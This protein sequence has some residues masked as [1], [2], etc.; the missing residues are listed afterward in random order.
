MCTL[1]ALALII[2]AVALCAYAASRVDSFDR[3]LTA[4]A[5]Y[6]LDRSR[7]TVRP[8]KEARP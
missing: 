8:R 1:T 4:E 2:G 5:R 6:A 7:R 3:D